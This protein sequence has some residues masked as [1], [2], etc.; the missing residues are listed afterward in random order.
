MI[1]HCLF[2]QSGTFKNVLKEH[3]YSAYDY[4]ILN[5]FNQVDFQVDLFKEISVE[6]QNIMSETKETTIFTNMSKEKDFIIAF[7]PCTHFSGLN[8]FQYKLLIAG[9]KRPLDKNS[10]NR[11]I[12]RNVERANYFEIYL[13]LCFICTIK[14]LPLIVENPA[15]SAGNHSYLEMFSPIPI[16]FREKDRRKFGDYLKKPTNYFA[17]NFEMKEKLKMFTPISKRITV[18]SLSGMVERSKISNLYAENFYERFL[19]K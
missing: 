1:Y 17:L 15:S 18:Q 2:E 4:D 10:V 11:L 16:G 9:K 19:E 8:E 13:K 6:Y 7:F 14:K 12:K 3:G 5:N